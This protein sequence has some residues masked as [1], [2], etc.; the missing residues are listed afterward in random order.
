[1]QARNVRALK[2]KLAVML[3][4][5]GWS[6][7]DRIGYTSKDPALLSYFNNLVKSLIGKEAKIIP[8]DRAFRAVVYSK[9]FVKELLKLS[10]TFRT[11]KLSNG[12]FP[13]AKIPDEVFTLPK[14]EIVEI[15][16]LIFS[17]EGGVTIYAR[18][19]KNNQ[20]TVEKKVFLS[21]ANPILVQQYTQLINLILKDVKMKYDNKG[22]NLYIKDKKG[23]EEFYKK[24]DFYLK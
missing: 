7:R 13:P 18:K 15:L 24:L 16:R 19:S 4:G 5:D 10:P 2:L 22:R 17:M 8:G 1:M 20:F 23:I 6:G 14:K 3:L 21:S 9:S 11:K 12:L